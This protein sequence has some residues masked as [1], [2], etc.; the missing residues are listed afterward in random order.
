MVSTFM[1]AFVVLVTRIANFIRGH[2]SISLPL[3][4]ST[5]LPCFICIPSPY[6]YIISRDY[7]YSRWLLHQWPDDFLDVDPPEVN[8]FHPPSPLGHEWHCTSCG[9]I[10]T[11]PCDTTAP[12]AITWT[13]IYGRL[14]DRRLGTVIP[15]ISFVDWPSHGSLEHSLWISLG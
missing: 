3:L 12:S 2:L 4:S 6:L 9:C 13:A 5:T 15:C 11:G 7:T 1:K 14:G 8:N 10:R